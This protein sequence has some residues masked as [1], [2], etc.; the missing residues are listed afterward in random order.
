MQLKTHSIFHS[1][2]YLHS[3]TACGS[4]CRSISSF[5]QILKP[6]LELICFWTPIFCL[7]LLKDRKPLKKILSF[8]AQRF[9]SLWAWA[10]SSSIC[11][12][13][14]NVVGL[15][16]MFLY[17][18]VCVGTW[19]SESLPNYGWNPLMPTWFLL[20]SSKQPRHRLAGYP[21][22][23]AELVIEFFAPQITD[24]KLFCWW[25]CWQYLCEGKHWF[26]WLFLCSGLWVGCSGHNFAPCGKEQGRMTQGI[27]D[28]LPGNLQR[29]Q[30]CCSVL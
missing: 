18:G 25:M 16:Y 8:L 26:V 17:F 12:G 11:C 10:S 14:S 1:G 4:S 15:W 20:V 5:V 24:Q 2:R 19:A 28:F 30:I 6:M 22:P 23:P 21:L 3:A 13:I 29:L 9:Q 27:A 7:A